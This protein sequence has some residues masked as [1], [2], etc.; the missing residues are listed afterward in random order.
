[1]A[2]LVASMTGVYRFKI[3]AKGGT[4]NGIP[5]TR[6]QILDAPVFNTGDQPH[7]GTTA[8]FDF[9][10]LLKCLAG[11]KGIQRYLKDK[12]IDPKMITKCIEEYCRRGGT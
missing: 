6:E 9:C 5:F 4:Y 10:Q 12:N 7:H 3:L 8:D 11:D 1:M 2:S